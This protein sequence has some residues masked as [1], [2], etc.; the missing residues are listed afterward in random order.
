MTPPTGI[1][2]LPE[3]WRVPVQHVSTCG[4]AVFLGLYYLFVIRTQDNARFEKMRQSIDELKQIVQADKA[5]I[6]DEQAERLERL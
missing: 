6:T 1:P 4:L 3:R 5:V 2:G